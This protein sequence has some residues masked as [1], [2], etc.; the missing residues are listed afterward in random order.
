MFQGAVRSNTHSQQK[1]LA[2]SRKALGVPESQLTLFD[3]PL[4]HHSSWKWGANIKLQVF[5]LQ[6]VQPDVKNH[7]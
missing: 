4:C 1:L 5:I 6:K 3:P 7:M 2:K